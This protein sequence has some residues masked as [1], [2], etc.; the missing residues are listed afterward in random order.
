M[1]AFYEHHQDSN[2][3]SVPGLELTLPQAGSAEQYR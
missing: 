3:R 1:N 2:G